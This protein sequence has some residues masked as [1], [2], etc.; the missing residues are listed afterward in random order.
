MSGIK[1]QEVPETFKQWRA[2]KGA[3]EIKFLILF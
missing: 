3:S 2:D 1:D